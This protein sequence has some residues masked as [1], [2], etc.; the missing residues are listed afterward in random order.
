MWC[1][2]SCACGCGCGC[3]WVLCCVVLCCA[4]LCCAVLCCAVLSCPVLSCPVLSCPVLRCVVLGWA[5]LGCVV[6]CAL[7]HVVRAWAAGG[8]EWRMRGWASLARPQPCP[9]HLTTTQLEIHFRSQGYA[10]RTN[11][12]QET[13]HNI[14]RQAADPNPASGVLKGALFSHTQLQVS[15]LLS[16]FGLGT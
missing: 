7:L 2:V 15:G 16:V 14:R 8:G 6:L 13:Q 4:V 10:P 5:V 11:F 3:G 9:E 12:N 1:D